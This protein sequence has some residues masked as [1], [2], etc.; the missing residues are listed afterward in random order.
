MIS[1]R[2]FKESDFGLICSWWK[3]AGE[4]APLPGMMTEDGTFVLEL[5]GD[6]VMTLSCLKTQTKEISYFEGYCARPGLPKAVRNAIGRVLWEHGYQYLRNSGFKRVLIFTNKEA[7]A[8]RYERLGMN[9]NMSG[10]Y[11]LGRVL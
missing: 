8:S 6:P 2:P 4:F 11:A 5:D 1:I 7:L 3:A 10:V 9:R